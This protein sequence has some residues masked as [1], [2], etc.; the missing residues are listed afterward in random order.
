MRLAPNVVRR[1]R[2]IGRIDAPIAVEGKGRLVLQKIHVRL[3]QALD[4]ADILPIAV[5]GVGEETRF[6][7]EHLR[8]DVLTEIVARHGVLR[9][10]FQVLLQEL[11][12]EDV[13]AHRGEIRLRLGRLLLELDDV[14]ILVGVH[15][16]EARRLFPRHLDDADRRLRLVPLV[17][18]KHPRVIHRVDMVTRKDQ[19]IVG[20]D[21]VDEVDVLIDGVRRS[22]IPVGALLARIGRQN[23]DAAILLVEIPRASRAE[24]VVKLQRTVLREDADLVDAGI[25]AVAQGKIND[26]VLAAKRYGGLCDLLRQGAQAASLPARQDHGQ[27]LCFSHKNPSPGRTLPRPYFT[28]LTIALFRPC[29]GNECL[30]LS[31]FLTFLYLFHKTRRFPA[32]IAAE[33]VF[34]SLF[35]TLVHGT[36]H[37]KKGGRTPPVKGKAWRSPR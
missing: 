20:I 32:V 37:I 29:G 2:R 1:Q 10:L 34:F 31:H 24:I 6:V 5:E 23:E 26:A 18:L 35:Q 25:G 19:H 12:V 17:R 4:R 9:I 28:L 27:I 14:P 7:G 15:D 21:D 36:R 16:A 8:D 30:A 33:N 3:P 13:N 22:L 11:A